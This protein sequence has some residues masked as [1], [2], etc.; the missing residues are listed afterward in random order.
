L[1]AGEPACCF[2]DNDTEPDF[3]TPIPEWDCSIGE[4]D[5]GKGEW[6]EDCYPPPGEPPDPKGW[7]CPGSCAG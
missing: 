4:D 3:C 6:H 1:P 2:C 5:L 7:S